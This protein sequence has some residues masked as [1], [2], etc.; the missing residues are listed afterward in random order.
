[1]LMEKVDI[2]KIEKFDDENYENNFTQKYII[3]IEGYS[4]LNNIGFIKNEIICENSI[5]EAIFSVYDKISTNLFVN[6]N[7]SIDEMMIKKYC[8]LETCENIQYTEF[9]FYTLSDEN[10]QEFRED[11]ERYFMLC[12]D[13]KIFN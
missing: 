13:K 10:I 12:E 8:L 11:E 2:E 5:N 6:Y 1:M 9:S 3:M 7:I 4:K